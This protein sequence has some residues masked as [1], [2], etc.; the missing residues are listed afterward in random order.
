MHSIMYSRVYD[1]LYTETYIHVYMTYYIE[2]HMFIQTLHWG[3]IQAQGYGSGAAIDLRKRPK[4]TKKAASTQIRQK[5][6]RYAKKTAN[7]LVG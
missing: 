4:Y 6:S 7:R 1:I 3:R 2:R 5:D